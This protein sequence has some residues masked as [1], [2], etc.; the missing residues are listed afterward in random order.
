M[1]TSSRRALIFDYPY[2]LGS[3]RAATS[4]LDSTDRAI[5]ITVWIR[6]IAEDD[7]AG[8]FK[9][10]RYPERE[11]PVRDELVIGRKDVIAPI[12]ALRA[13]PVRVVVRIHP[14]N[15]ARW[16]ARPRVVF[17]ARPRNR[18]IVLPVR[19]LIDA[20][21]VFQAR[22]KE[23]VWCRGIVNPVQRIN[24]CGLRRRERIP[25][26]QSKRINQRDRVASNILIYL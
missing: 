4:W 5:T 8:G 17:V 1:P 9:E 21:G 13:F 15:P 10:T 6:V 19:F 20:A 24:S 26:R 3:V 14:A 2:S 11:M 22:R 23:P 12:H 16:I 7:P 25:W 18:C